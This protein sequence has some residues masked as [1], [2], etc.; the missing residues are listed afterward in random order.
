MGGDGELVDAAYHADD[1]DERDVQDEH[2]EGRRGADAVQLDGQAA[3]D[4][5]RLQRRAQILDR[6]AA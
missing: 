2:V 6:A 1:R 4:R 3:V 5:A